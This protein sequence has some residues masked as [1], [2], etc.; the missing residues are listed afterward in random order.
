MLGAAAI[1]QRSSP[2]EPP[3]KS[4]ASFLVD[5]DV[6]LD[7]GC[8]FR[9]SG[10]LVFRIPVDRVIGDR[11]KLL[12]NGLIRANAKLSMPAYD[13]DFDFDDSPP[14]PERDRVFFNDQE[15]PT[16]FLRG[17]DDLDT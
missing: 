3:K 6:G 17:Q 13:V 11:D 5:S 12:A 2:F 7:T 9:D 10:P 16:S 4:D 14:N 15:V 8:T 1:L